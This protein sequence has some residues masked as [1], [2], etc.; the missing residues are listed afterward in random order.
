MGNYRIYD[1]DGNEIKVHGRT[2]VCDVTV[3]EE[4]YI[5]EQKLIAFKINT[6]LFFVQLKFMLLDI[7]HYKQLL[8]Y[9]NTLQKRSLF[10]KY[11]SEEEFNKLTLPID[12]EWKKCYTIEVTIKGDT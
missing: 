1:T 3:V 2:N 11:V 6:Y 5:R 10:L 9:L 12:N 7:I 8:S 4:S